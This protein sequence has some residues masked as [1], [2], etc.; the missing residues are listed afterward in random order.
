MTLYL[1]HFDTKL[2]Q[3]LEVSEPLKNC[4]AEYLF[5]DTKFTLGEINPDTVKAQDLRPYKG[6][7]LQFASGKRMYF[8]EHP[9][10]DLLYPNAS[11]GAAYGSLP[12]T[13]CQKFSEIKQ[14]RV[15]I[16]DDST[17]AS[18]GILPLQIA[19][20]LVGDC[21]GKMSL[22]LAEQLTGSKNAP[23]QFRLGIRPQDGCDVY[24][25][26][27]GTLA[28]DPRLETLTSGVL[29]LQ[30]KVKTGYDLILPTSSFKGRKGADSI[31]PGEYLLDLGIGVK[32]I[33][34]YGKQSLGTQVLVNYPKGV[35]TDIVPIIETLADRL[36]NAQSDLHALAKH[37]VQTYQARTVTIEEEDLKDFDLSPL[38]ALNKED[39]E[40][41][42]TQE[43]VFYDLLKTDLEHH[44][45]LLEHPFVIDELK[46]FL[47][48][49][50]MDIAT[51]RAIK[52]HSALAQP[53]LDLGENEV[54]VPLLPDGAE[55]IVTRSPLVNSNGVITLTNRHL[56]GLMHLEGTIHIHPETA[57]KHLQADFDGDRL[58]FER[59]DKYP[60][61]TAEI[62]EALLPENRYPDVVKRD[63][64]AYKGT[65]EEIATKSVKNDIGKIANQI[66]RAVSL[67]WET[68]LMPQ[69]K[70]EDYV[71]QVAKYYGGILAKDASPDNKFS[72]PQQ[73][74]QTIQEIANL[75]QELSPQQIETALQQMRDIQYLIV[76]DLSNELQVAVDGPKS[77]N[78]PNA[79]ILNICRL[80]GGYQPVA[81]LSGRDK[82]R[83]PQVYRTHPLESRN[84]SPIDRMIGVA[85]EKWTENRLLSRPVHQFQDFFP[86]VGNPNLTDI[87]GEIKETY[88]DYLKRARTLTDLKTEHPELI[89]PHIEVTS[90]T[91]QRKIYLTRLERFG[92]LES[93]LL[94]TDKP[95]TLDLKLVNNQIDREIPNTLLAVATFNID[96]KL[97]QQPV[98]AIAT[99]STEQYN[100]K[101]GRTLLQ[102]SALLRPGITDGRIQGIYKQLDEYVDRVRKQ[103]PV[104][105][106]RELAAAL[107][108]NAHTRD[109][110]QTKKALLA[111]KLFPDEVIQ[112]LSKLQFTELKVVGL[113][114]PTNEYGNKQWRGEEA[115]CEIALHPI[116][117]KSGQLEEK[118]VILVESKVLAPLTGESPAMAVGTKFKASILA[119]PSSGVIATTLKG[120][121]L[122]I[123]QIKNFAYREHSWQGQEAKINI[124]LVNNGKGRAIP[125]VT[126]DGNALGIL[127]RESERELRERNLLNTKGLTLVARLSNTPSTTAQIMVKPETVLYPWQQRELEKQ[128][129]AK[130]G[131]YRQQ[132]EAYA[133]DILRNAP[134]V[135]VSRHLIDVEVARLAYADTGDS[136]EVA[137]ILSQS[138]QVR[139][140]RASVPNALSW[141]EYVNQ[142]KE[143]V[144]YVQ[145]AAKD[146]AVQM[147]R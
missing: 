31:K 122:K 101:A 27:K 131:V 58:A 82:S 7:S 141:E 97:V 9:V 8:S 84:Y 42:Q 63:K 34:S 48:Q 44:G 108:H 127:D 139:Q 55:L 125:L 66:M 144:R 68:V 38:D 138:D 47:Q 124:A 20:K 45:Q 75:P 83:N 73:Y 2:R 143:Y 61:L 30:G 69:E 116:P 98:G 142:A 11:D 109:E 85:N 123:G 126:L 28:P 96:G 52:F 64:I 57:A 59:A 147:Y 87:A 22:L 132:Y 130:R 15:L 121:T 129:E 145:S 135:G 74:K 102:S 35:Q 43:R 25:I 49:R 18:G 56:P 86:S 78:R 60:T 13:P 10:R 76:G 93:G 88:N 29:Q 107:W 115:D 65:F 16:I 53:S 23:I 21:H 106:R 146:R 54:C 79:A 112:Q 105:E 103:H 32:A 71:K 94:A 99:S 81:W 89:E 67:R 62:K 110:Y 119:E 134:L 111:F 117:D 40:N 70:K 114:F 120:N 4:L 6:M 140:W 137:T 136:H 46:K 95:F 36:A 17:G 19:K 77:A 51:G 80:I 33:A 104:N 92:A 100:L 91:S 24:R 41:I 5:P 50:W 72:I 128:M 12:F 26:A 133:S 37:F 14:A 3:D 113:H 90:A 1:T 118:R 39:A